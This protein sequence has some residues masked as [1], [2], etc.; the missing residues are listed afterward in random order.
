MI[1]HGVERNVIRAT[2]TTLIALLRAWHVAGG[3]SISPP[4]Q[5]PSANSGGALYDRIRAY[6]DHF[7]E[8]GR[9]LDRAVGAYNKAVG[10]IE[11][12]V[13]VAARKIKELGASARGDVE[14]PEIVDKTARILRKEALVGL[15]E[16]AEQEKES[17]DGKTVSDGQVQP[18]LSDGWF[19]NCHGLF[20]QII[21]LINFAAFS[22]P[23]PFVMVIIPNLA[24]HLTLT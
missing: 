18:R 11:G 13:L 24:C 1:E 2:P 19:Q 23:R 14:S 7:S 21:L 12:R 16:T 4:L 6:T 10:S 3:R 20:V 8:V 9:G 5:L 22:I 15:A 17:N